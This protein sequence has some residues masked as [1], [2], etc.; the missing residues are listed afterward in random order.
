MSTVTEEVVEK[1]LSQGNDAK[2][3]LALG[4]NLGLRIWRDEK[5]NTDKEMHSHI[6]ETVGYV[7]KGRA[8]LHLE[9]KVIEL[10]EGDSYLV[11][12]S[13]EHTYKI[14]ETFSAI[15]ATSPPA[16]IE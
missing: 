14:L 13:A 8:E 16:H 7:L 12:K 9:D 2:E 4:E 3:I 10:V 5:P 1:K 11:P 15:E 6:Y